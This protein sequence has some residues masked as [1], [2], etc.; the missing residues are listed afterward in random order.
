MCKLRLED[1][2][3]LTRPRKSGIQNRPIWLQ[4]LCPFYFKPAMRAIGIW[5]LHP[6]SFQPGQ[7]TV[8]V[9]WLQLKEL[10][11]NSASLTKVGEFYVWAFVIG[12]GVTTVTVWTSL[13][14]PNWD[15]RYSGNWSFPQLWG[16]G[17]GLTPPTVDCG[18]TSLWSSSIAHFLWYQC[19][20]K[21][22]PQVP[23]KHKRTLFSCGNEDFQKSHCSVLEEP[24]D[25]AQ[26]ILNPGQ[27]PD[28]MSLKLCER[29]L[30]QSETGSCPTKTNQFI[31][32][33]HIPL[34][35]FDYGSHIQCAV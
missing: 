4:R 8:W 9:Q 5:C 6:R 12:D 20:F 1:L 35:T 27:M 32:V 7:V 26:Q 11:A 28:L 15:D 34:V 30:L 10:S 23:S 25:Y 16:M 13:N 19:P 29:S 22:V 21:V 33:L 2:S 18:L 31:A 17:I 14:F 3:N 24:K